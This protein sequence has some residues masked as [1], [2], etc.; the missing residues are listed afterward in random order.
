MFCSKKLVKVL[1]SDLGSKNK[2][3][4]LLLLKVFLKFTTDLYKIECH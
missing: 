3:W 4:E 1:E 2:M